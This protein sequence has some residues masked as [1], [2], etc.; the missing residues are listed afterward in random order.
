MDFK[1]VSKNN[2]GV[3]VALLL[4]ILLSQAKF[5]NFLLDTALGR[6]VLVFLVLILAYVNKILGVVAVLFIIILFNQSD[7]GYLEGFTAAPT[8][9]PS[10]TSTTSPSA[11]ST[12]SPSATSTTSP[13]ATSTTSTTPNANQEARMA[14]RQKIRQNVKANLASKA[15]ASAA[16]A[17]TPTTTPSAT[18]SL[19]TAGAE[20][21]DL[22]GT[23][24]NIK[25]G[26]QSN[27]IPVSEHMR[28]SM[29]V[30]AF[31]GSFSDNYSAF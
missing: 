24:N 21:F 10:A 31:D 17:T 16:P 23:E 20:G 5:F 6:S 2:I 1:L 27:K 25:R 11:T 30:S 3:V 14:E 22:I 28:E 26:K 15:A 12:T 9:S 18:A 4:V 29:N 13:S 7:I 19:T 8:T